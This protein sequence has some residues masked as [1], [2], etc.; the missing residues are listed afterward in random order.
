M[1]IYSCL[2][3]N[4]KQKERE[5]DDNTGEYIYIGGGF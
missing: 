2:Q 4:N 3:A 5:L 1:T